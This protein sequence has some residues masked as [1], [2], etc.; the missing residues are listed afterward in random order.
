MNTASYRHLSNFDDSDSAP[1]S[2][3]SDAQLVDEEPD[4]LAAS[5]ALAAPQRHRFT[6]LFLACSLQK[7]SVLRLKASDKL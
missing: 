4:E 5:D 6:F 1:S 3:E 7:P 2:D